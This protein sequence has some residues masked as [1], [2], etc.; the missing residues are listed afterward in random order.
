MEIHNKIVDFNKYCPLCKHFDINEE[1]DPCNECLTEPTNIDS[2][3]PIN[4]VEDDTK[5]K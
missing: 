1:K 2:R 3:K 4:F 5:K